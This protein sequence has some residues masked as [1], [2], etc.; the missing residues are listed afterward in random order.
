MTDI[1]DYLKDRI[2]KARKMKG[3]TQEVLAKELGMDPA[4]I[5]RYEKGHRIPDANIL[6]QMVRIF[7]CNSGWL[8][9]GEGEMEK[10]EKE[11]KFD[12]V[13]DKILEK[14]SAMTEVQKTKILDFIEEKEFMWK[15]IEK[16][17][18]AINAL[19]KKLK[20]N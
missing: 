8:L 16:E 14:V 5:N 2:K 12:P 19:K 17:K 1:Q 15:S 11:L 10:P 9:T 7:D 20:V 3:L 13:T 18:E 6:C 4:T